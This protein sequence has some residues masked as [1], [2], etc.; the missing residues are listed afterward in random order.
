MGNAR[1]FAFWVVLFLLVFAVFSMFRNGGTALQSQEK[2]YSEFVQMVGGDSVSQVTLNGEQVMFTGTDGRD[3]FAIKPTDAN[4]TDFLISEDVPVKAE[5]TGTIVVL[6][7][8]VVAVPVLAANR[9]LDLFHEPDARRRQRRRDGVR[10]I[11][12]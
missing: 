1:N 12:G 8:P 3:Y 10:Q 7:V 9:C 11:Q 2:S 5:K 6:D 4:V